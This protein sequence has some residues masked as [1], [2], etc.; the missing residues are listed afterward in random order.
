MSGKHLKKKENLWI[1]FNGKEYCVGLT[2]EAQKD[3]S[4][5]I[6]INLPKVGRTYQAGEPLV[7]VESEKAVNEFVSP[8]T[9]KISSINE[10]ISVL[11]DRDE[12]NAWILSFK[13]VNP[14]QFEE[15]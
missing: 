6:Y 2:K 4:E 11:N 15:L 1:L 14:Q 8:L 5:I 9:G 13:E 7:E 3:L 12:M 10:D